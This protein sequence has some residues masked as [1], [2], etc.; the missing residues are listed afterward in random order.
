MISQLGLDLKQSI[1]FLVNLI[2]QLRNLFANP[3]LLR[4]N[5]RLVLRRLDTRVYELL[6]VGNQLSV[7]RI[8]VCDLALQVF[9]V[10]LQEVAL[11][12]SLFIICLA[13]IVA[14][15]GQVFVCKF[16]AV[17]SARAGP[18]NVDD[19]LQSTRRWLVMSRR[20]PSGLIVTCWFIRA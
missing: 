12:I 8:A 20:K 5:R 10:V 17:S 3:Q 15:Q 18:S 19:G 16:L 6:P 11:T 1:R 2:D 4:F 7:P 13:F 14:R 9:D